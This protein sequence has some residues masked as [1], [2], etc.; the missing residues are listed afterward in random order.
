MRVQRQRVERQPELLLLCDLTKVAVASMDIM[1]VPLEALV[2]VG[3]SKR[4]EGSRCIA[5]QQHAGFLEQ[6]T[7]RGHMKCAGVFVGEVGQLS[8]SVS[9]AITPCVIRAVLGIDPSARK[10]MRAS[11]R[12][13]A[14]VPPHHEHF[15]PVGAVAQNED[16]GRGTRNVV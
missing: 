13:A 12:T 7:N 4:D 9:H 8:S 14:F 2:L 1:T 10:N 15:R 5:G 16:G 6:F 11:K 3:S